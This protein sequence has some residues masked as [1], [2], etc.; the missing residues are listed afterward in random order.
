MLGTVRHVILLRLKK[1][2]NIF[3]HTAHVTPGDSGKQIET[4][5]SFEQTMIVFL[6]RPTNLLCMFPILAHMKAKH[7]AAALRRSGKVR[8]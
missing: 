1:S 7:W 8:V 5:K 4:R 3:A 2:G 6:S